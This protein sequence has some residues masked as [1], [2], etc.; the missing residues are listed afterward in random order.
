[1]KFS[2]TQRTRIK[3]IRRLI[4]QAEFIGWPA[5][6]ESLKSDL[7]RCMKNPAERFATVKQRR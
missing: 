2:L 4:E 6:A 1:M 7:K 5:L 3:R